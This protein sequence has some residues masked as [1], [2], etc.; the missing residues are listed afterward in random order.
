MKTGWSPGMLQDDC[1]ELSK[2]L[3]TRVDSRHVAREAAKEIEMSK[4]IELE[5][6]VSYAVNT[7]VHGVVMLATSDAKE[8][9]AELRRLDAENAQLRAELEAIYSAGP[10]AWMHESGNATYAG[11]D[12]GVAAYNIP[13]IQ[14][15]VRK[16]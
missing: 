1:R 4:A 12:A 11:P 13:L 10:V 9:A 14:K 8:I 15:P 6:V 7:D 2:W 16:S 3:S 5:G